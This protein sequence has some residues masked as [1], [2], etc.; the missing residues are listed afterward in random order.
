MALR[1]YRRSRRKLMLFPLMDMFFIL[2]LFFLVTSGFSPDPPEE[3]GT[4][5]STPNPALGEAQILLQVVSPDSSIW[6]DNTAF[7]GS[8]EKGTLLTR[9]GVH[10]DIESLTR[11]FERFRRMVGMCAGRTILTAVRCPDNLVYG[12]IDRLQ[13]NL[14]AAF[15][16]TIPG[17]ELTFGL[18]PGTA[19]QIL[20]DSIAGG[21]DR[22]EIRWR[23]E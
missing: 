10:H 7:S 22:V 14:E 5:I 17:Y 2:L 1:R 9:N 16:K 19:D 15:A 21:G 3:R 4:F 12:D 18:V 23:N 6:L 11:R 20:I 13:S 8:W